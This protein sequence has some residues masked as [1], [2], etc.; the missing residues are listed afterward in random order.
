[1][2]GAAYHFGRDQRERDMRRD[3]ELAALGWL[4]LRFS[5]RRM[6]SDPA[7]VR[8]EITRVIAMRRAQLGRAV[9]S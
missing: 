7:G 3:A 4:V 9:G 8:R 1:M 2:D 5:Y 6:T